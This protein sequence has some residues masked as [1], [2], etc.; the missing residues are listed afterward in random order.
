MDLQL[1][2][3]AIK[4][5]SEI[6]TLCIT[7]EYLSYNTRT[8]P[9]TAL[10]APKNSLR[11]YPFLL[12]RRS[13]LVARRSAKRPQQR[14]ARRNGCFRRLAKKG[15]NFPFNIFS[16]VIRHRSHSESLFIPQACHTAIPQTH[17]AFY[18]QRFFGGNQAVVFFLICGLDYEEKGL[19]N[20]FSRSISF[21]S[22]SQRFFFPLLVGLHGSTDSI[23]RKSAIE[24]H[25][26]VPL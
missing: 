6:I 24:G 1:D 12:A 3:A 7:V 4:Y 26:P 8:S 20:Q 17:S 22:Q 25:D 10:L 15:R 9:A 21:F 19:L 14:R 23:S 5:P 2:V 11:K 18:P 16:S 13:S